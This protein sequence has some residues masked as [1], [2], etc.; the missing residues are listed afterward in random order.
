MSDR[1]I[2]CDTR[3]SGNHSA[4]GIR[5]TASTLLNEEGTFNGAEWK[6][7]SPTTRRRKRRRRDEV[8]QHHLTK[9]DKNNIRGVYNC[10]A[11]WFDCVR[12]NRLDSLR[13]GAVAISLRRSAA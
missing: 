12:F 1:S 11:Y 7:N 6:P 3:P 9:G 4:D 10:T 2:G 13:N 8:V 5:S